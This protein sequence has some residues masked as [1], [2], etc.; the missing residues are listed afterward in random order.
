VHCAP[1]GGGS[2][3]LSSSISE[4]SEAA[5]SAF[6]NTQPAPACP[7]HCTLAAAPPL[8]GLV[9][10]VKDVTL[11]D[12][13]AKADNRGLKTR[14]ERSGAPTFTS[15]LELQVGRRQQWQ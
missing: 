6:Q 12:A 4:G 1:A 2:C 14:L 7:A 9:G 5:S 13:T 3:I 15:L 11:G 8:Q 10:G